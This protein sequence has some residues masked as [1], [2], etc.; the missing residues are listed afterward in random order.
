V[1]RARGIIY[2]SEWW[3]AC[4]RG[5]GGVCKG[6]DD[7]ENDDHQCARDYPFAVHLLPFPAQGAKMT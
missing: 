6:A 1:E 3:C 2:L 4:A 7:D 5:C